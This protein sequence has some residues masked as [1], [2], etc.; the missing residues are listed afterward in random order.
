M[1]IVHFQLMK[2]DRAMVLCNKVDLQMNRLGAWPQIEFR[3]FIIAK[4]N[5]D[6]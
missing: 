3:N 1:M 5:K 4:G 6:E 2:I